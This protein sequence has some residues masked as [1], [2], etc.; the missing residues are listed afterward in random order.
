M[1]ETVM[2]PLVCSSSCLMTSPAVKVNGRM[3]G[4]TVATYIGQ[5]SAAVTSQKHGD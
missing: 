1:D 4:Q 3:I 2:G 5:D